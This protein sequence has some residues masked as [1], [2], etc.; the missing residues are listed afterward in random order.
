MKTFSVVLLKIFWVIAS[1]WAALVCFNAV[2]GNQFLSI[3]VFDV[4]AFC[5][6]LAAVVWSLPKSRRQSCFGML[7]L[8]CFGLLPGMFTMLLG[9]G[10]AVETGRFQAS[11]CFVASIFLALNGALH[12]G[13]TLCAMLGFIK[14]DYQERLL[15]KTK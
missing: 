6:T 14:R 10:L 5:P 15:A 3:G 12:V 9:S 2:R 7:A 8:L 13:L 11:E 1:L 4:Y